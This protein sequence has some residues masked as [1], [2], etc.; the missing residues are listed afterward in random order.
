MLFLLFPAGLQGQRWDIEKTYLLSPILPAQ[1]TPVYPRPTNKRRTILKSTRLLPP[2]PPYSLPPTSTSTSLLGHHPTSLGSTFHFPAPSPSPSTLIS[3][4][5]LQTLP[6]C[7]SRNNA[8]PTTSPSG[9]RTLLSILPEERP[10]EEGAGEEGEGEEVETSRTSVEGV[11]RGRGEE[12]E[13]EGGRKREERD[14]ERVSAGREKRKGR[15]DDTHLDASLSFVDKG[16]SLT[17]TIRFLVAPVWYVRTVS[18]WP[19]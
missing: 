2:S 8:S 11:G 6:T 10:R 14:G 17:G 19:T 3:P 1:Q 13:W 7:S 5:P 15:R 12:L 9:V 4:S 16:T 18:S